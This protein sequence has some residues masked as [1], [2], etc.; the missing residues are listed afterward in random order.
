MRPEA[1]FS[2]RARFRHTAKKP[3]FVRV[4][5]WCIDLA[6][7]HG[8]LNIPVIP[9]VIRDRDLACSD[10]N[11]L[12]ARNLFDLHFA[13][14]HPNSQT[15]FLWDFDPDLR[16]IAVPQMFAFDHEFPTDRIR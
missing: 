2:A 12:V 13:G 3:A 4:V 9:I 7:A 11:V 10:L 1:E 15:G 16:P 14:K 6:D 8:R 5:H